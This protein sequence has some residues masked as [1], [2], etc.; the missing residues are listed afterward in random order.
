MSRR[1]K[2]VYRHEP[3]KKY[4]MHKVKKNWVVKGG[5]AG[6][7]LVG[8]V[9]SPASNLLAHAAENEVVDATGE[10]VGTVASSDPVEEVAQQSNE[11]V[12]AGTDMPQ[13]P[14]PRATENPDG[15]KTWVVNEDAGISIDKDTVHRVDKDGNP[16]TSSYSSQ[17]MHSGI[18][19]IMNL[20]SE[21]AKPKNGDKI[22][23]PITS[24]RSDL[25]MAKGQGAFARTNGTIPGL[26]TIEY[27]SDDVGFVITVTSDMD[28]E[29][30]E[31][32][33]AISLPGQ[34]DS[35]TGLGQG[36]VIYYSA[37]LKKAIYNPINIFFGGQLLE[38]VTTSAAVTVYP[39]TTTGYTLSSNFVTAPNVLIG[40]YLYIN[41]NKT[42]SSLQEKE[43]KDVP[44]NI[45]Q[46]QKIEIESTS[47][48][49]SYTGEDP[50]EI[51]LGNAYVVMPVPDESGAQYFMATT[52]TTEFNFVEV[53]VNST[54]TQIM[55]ILE[56]AG[57]NTYTVV[58]QSDNTFITARNIGTGANGAKLT[59][60]REFKESGARTPAEY[61]NL[62]YG[63]S[64]TPEFEAKVNSTYSTVP[65]STTQRFE[66]TL[67][68][69]SVPHMMTVVYRDSVNGV[70]T[71]SKIGSQP[72]IVT[73]REQSS[74]VANYETEDGSLADVSEAIASGFPDVTAAITPKEIAGYEFVEVKEVPTGFVDN[75]DGTYTYTFV[76]DTNEEVTFIYRALERKVKVVDYLVDAEGQ[77]TQLDERDMKGT[78]GSS[79]VITASNHR[80]D[81]YVLTNQSA[82]NFYTVTGEE[83]QTVEYHYK[84]VGMWDYDTSAYKG[85][86]DLSALADARYTVNANLTTVANLT[87]SGVPAGYHLVGPNGTIHQNGATIT[88]A[89]ATEDTVLT[90]TP[91]SAT[92]DYT[93]EDS[94]GGE[95]SPAINVN[96]AVGDEITDRA[97]VIEGYYL[98]KTT[99]TGFDTSEESL[100]KIDSGGAA[101]VVYTY[102]EMGSYTFVDENGSKIQESIKY[103]NHQTDPT[104]RNPDQIIPYVRVTP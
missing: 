90:L 19:F 53:P 97:T 47:A 84:Q 81:G 96:A 70:S 15:T 17:A 28:Q 100:G 20:N 7:M 39:E 101:T 33:F 63:I 35:Y 82:M 57:A 77:K 49:A 21:L 40:S 1:R 87:V 51:L 61:F 25:P 23:I 50:N 31:K 41:N 52:Y 5:V 30:G 72:N 78:T 18:S 38:T 16:V 83:E 43:P 6:A 80:N 55:E 36:F 93:F 12:A 58:R 26:G 27:E 68:D 95:L 65:T 102:K 48:I 91:N 42:G 37:E 3:I 4:R 2:M 104:Q 75:E 9:A 99:I 62:I 8:T 86:G 79:L 66:F 73:V 32:E 94:S 14:Q 60:S 64:Y 24:D 98:D 69:D 54:E 22:I 56:K 71:P 29:S 11:V 89:D 10:G 45:V 59:D 85:S 76:E 46:L 92:L 88:P 13:R 44:E 103:E 74:L 67:E 34:V